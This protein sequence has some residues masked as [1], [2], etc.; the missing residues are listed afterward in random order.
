MDISFQLL[1]IQTER[2]Q[3]SKYE[4]AVSKKNRWELKRQRYSDNEWRKS[5][6]GQSDSEERPEIWKLVEIHTERLPAGITTKGRFRDLSHGAA[7]LTNASHTAGLMDEY[8][9]TGRD[10][11][12]GHPT[13]PRGDDSGQGTVKGWVDFMEE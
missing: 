11:G 6:I 2:K 1:S 3:M 9:F 4:K 5:R 7:K 8:M 13:D 10:E 12:G